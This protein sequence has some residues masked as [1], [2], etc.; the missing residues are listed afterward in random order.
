MIHRDCWIQV[1]N[2]RED[3]KSTKLV[4]K[5][6]AGIGMGTTISAAQKVVIEEYALLARNIYI[7][8]H[9]HAF[10]D[11]TIPIMS[12]G[13]ENPEPV[14]IGRHSW[15]CQNVCILPGVSIGEHSVIGA[16]SVVKSSIPAFSV[17]VGSPARVVKHYNI[18]CGVWERV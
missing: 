14:T 11:V 15:L 5:S 13:I 7:S 16:N 10:T 4:I 6:H 1:L 8:D 2:G 9:A 3:E 17:A 12:Q 18:N